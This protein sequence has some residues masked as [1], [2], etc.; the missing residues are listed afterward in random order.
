MK[1]FKITNTILGWITFIISLI[2]YI[3]TL[4]PSVSLWDCG[5][6]ISASYRL[7][8]VH[9]PGA[10]LF[11]MLG[12]L[13]TIFAEPGT[14]E[15]AI[16]V[17]MLSATASAATVMLTFWITVH[18]GKKLVGVGLNDLEVDLGK[19][20]SILG[21]GLV[22][23][24]A[25]TFMDSFW[26]SAVEA[27]VY[28]SSSAFMALA[29]WAILRW[30]RVKEQATADRW[31]VFVA[32][33]VGLGIGLHL[34][35]LLVI[36]AIIYYYFFNKYPVTRKN[37]YKATA[38][39]FGAIAILQWGIIPKTPKVAAMFDMLFVNSLNMPYNSGVLFFMLLVGLATAFALYYTK[40]KN[41]PIA[42][43]V[44]LCFAFVMMGF[45]SYTMVVV[46]SLADPPIDMNDPDNAFDLES[47]INRE[48]YGERPLLHGNHWNAYVIAINDGGTR[49]R[50][51]ENG[52]EEAGTKIE[53]EF[54]KAYT[55]WFPRMSD[56]S[57]KSRGYPL[58]AGMTDVYNEINNTRDQLSQRNLDDKQRAELNEKLQRL[59]RVKPSMAD[60]ITFMFKYQ[61]GWMYMRYFMWNFVGR[62]NDLQNV[63][64]N[65][66][67][68]NWLSGISVIDNARLGPQSDVPKELAYNKAR[69]TYFFL[70]LILGLLGIFYQY[71]NQ[72]LDFATVFIMF[73]FTG[74]LVV[75]YLNQPPNEP[76]ERDYT[77]VG[78]Y[79]TF[80]I[81]I[82]LSVL[83]L[84]DLFKRYVNSK[85]AAVGA[86]TIALFAAPILMAQQNWDDHDR[87]D[88]YL[89]VSFAKMYL[90]SCKPNAIL[91]TSGDNDTY[92]LWY[93]QNVE[94]I[95]TDVRIINLSLLPTEWYS[96][97]L[98]RKVFKSEPLPLDIPEDKLNKGKR[99]YLSYVKNDAFSQEDFYRLRDVLNFMTKDDARY[100]ARNS[101]G[102]QVNY[103]PVR[104]FSIPI[105]K[106]QVL[107]GGVVPLQDSAYIVDQINWDIGTSGLSKG[108]IVVL[109]FLDANARTGWTRPVYWTTTAG[110]SAYLN[111]TNFMR[112]NGLIYELLPI[113]ANRAMRG[114]DDMDIIYNNLMNKFEWGNMDKGTMFL[115]EK[116]SFVPHNLRQYF[117]QAADYY[118]NVGKHDSAMAL[119]EKCYEAIPESILPMRLELKIASAEVYYRA[120]EFD[121]G[122]AYMKAVAEDAL[123][124]IQYCNKFDNTGKEY[125]VR[126][127]SGYYVNRVMDVVR[128]SRAYG[129]TEIADQYDNILKAFRQ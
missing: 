45:S 46:R 115:D 123:E 18:F 36:P 22:A 55:T 80:C 78:S 48:Q 108:D 12:K 68:G 10:P 86:T 16:A 58:W 37:I 70:P 74:L 49:Y 19:S 1:N 88:R 38:I 114:M 27:E 40:Q 82:G 51:G 28:A 94:G 24:L 60:N 124:M 104:K 59:E 118:S 125:Q 128:T 100:M 101:S 107:E 98:R 8:V 3:L 31:L 99:E 83:F 109:D 67:N 43:L 39:G 96:D 81:W 47:Y 35:N 17:N 20:I 113:R 32:Y 126:R 71:K 44:V 56:R 91:F 73:I 90:E 41:K 15:V 23:A 25:V 7:Q 76:R 121:K 93:A 13:F 85:M 111:L 63:D 122:D 84:T 21:S 116:A 120:K 5:E 112:N 127:Q 33:T 129:R 65:L 29:F 54:E 34:L 92:P 105:D 61:I 89:G 87:S 42:N 117:V 103:Y 66:Q 52:Y 6:F 11:L 50:A 53:P 4:E 64:G 119:I 2:V 14:N 62:Q 106:M 26:F 102:E 30:E 57:E 9:P 95:R 72:K 75:I 110:N 69:N 79:Q 97:A 77:N